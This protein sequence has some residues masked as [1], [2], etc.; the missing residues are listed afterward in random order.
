MTDGNPYQRTAEWFEARTGC[1]TASAIADILPSVKVLKSGEIKKT[2]REA[3]EKLMNII[4]AER[5]SGIAR[6]NYTSAAMQWGIEHEDNARTAYEVHTGN[7]VELTGFIPH[8]DVKY[9][10]ASPDGLI[11]DGILE[12]KCPN[13]DGIPFSQQPLRFS[14]SSPYVCTL[15]CTIR[16]KQQKTPIGNNHFTTSAKASCLVAQRCHPSPHREPASASRLTM[17]SHRATRALRV[18]TESPLSLRRALLSRSLA[19]RRSRSERTAS[20]S[21]CASRMVSVADASF[22]ACVV[23]SFWTAS[24]CLRCIPA[25]SAK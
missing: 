8:P 1:L 23:C 24:A 17:R 14:A 3:R 18:S 20:Y 2:Y 25:I 11:D 19:R 7:L 4:I 10:G 13:G 9:L 15:V 21:D 22:A 12:I 16:P 6:D 5:V